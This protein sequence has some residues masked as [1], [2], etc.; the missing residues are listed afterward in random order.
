M[1]IGIPAI[2]S[3]DDGQLLLSTDVEVEEVPPAAK[4]SKLS[5]CKHQETHENI[6]QLS[7]RAK[8]TEYTLQNSSD[9]QE[10]ALFP[11]VCKVSYSRYMIDYIS[12]IFHNYKF[13][14]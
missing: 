11:N 9:F 8:N 5:N 1:E 3:P 13:Q 10:T 12:H 7:T 4:K 2:I 14:V 6:V